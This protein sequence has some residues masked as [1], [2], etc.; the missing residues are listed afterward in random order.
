MEG[1]SNLSIAHALCISIGTVKKLV[2]NCFK[3][4]GVSTRYEL[5]EFI[6]SD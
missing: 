1:Y 5:V 4:L 6:Y 3:K 2:Y